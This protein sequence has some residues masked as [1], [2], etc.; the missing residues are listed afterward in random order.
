MKNWI[1]FIVPTISILISGCNFT[2]EEKEKL[3][4]AQIDLEQLAD[5]IIITYPA[6]GADVRDGV[7]PIRADIPENAKAQVV[8]LF[9]DGILV[10]KDEDG[11]PWEIEFPAYFWADDQPHTLLLKTTTG[12]GNEVRNNQQYSI[13]ISSEA[14]SVLGFSEESKNLFIEEDAEIDIEVNKLQHASRYEFQLVGSEWSETFSEADPISLQNLPFG[15]WQMRYRAINDSLSNNSLSGPWSELTS[16][17]VGERTLTYG[18]SNSDLITHVISAGNGSYIFVANTKS[19]DLGFAVDSAGDDWVTKI[20]AN[21]GKDWEYFYLKEGGPKFKHAH[22]D[23]NGN[24]WLA[25][26]DS[27]SKSGVLTLLGTNGEYLWDKYYPPED[28]VTSIQMSSPAFESGWLHVLA[29]EQSNCGGD[30]TEVSFKIYKVD[31]LNGDIEESIDIPNIPEIVISSVSHIAF[32]DGLL[33]LGGSGR[34]ASSSEDDIYDY[35]TFVGRINLSEDSV[36]NVWE[37]MGQFENLSISDLIIANNSDAIVI[38]QTEPGGI[39]VSRI[40]ASGIR[41]GSYTNHEE[42]LS[43]HSQLGYTE[44]GGVGVVY[45]GRSGTGPFKKH[46]IEFEF[47]LTEVDRYELNPQYDEFDIVLNS[48]DTSVTTLGSDRFGTNL[49]YDIFYS[50]KK[51]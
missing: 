7:I 24:T 31:P 12:G 26:S 4:D 5:Q 14:S 28:P 36:V 45:N 33:I 30:C 15:T 22:Y 10:G 41:V 1:L 39:S 38:G 18:G 40:N 47:P 13:N 34:P 43:M 46:V 9:V 3:N 32:S 44:L 19:T 8:E 16:I 20:D 11:A 35:G 51:K 49:N 48:S 6:N 42:L 23:S 2:E 17:A 50:K 29:R 37:N 25:G 27:D 21:G